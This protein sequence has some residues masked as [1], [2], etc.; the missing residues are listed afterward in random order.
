MLPFWPW[1]AADRNRAPLVLLLIALAASAAAVAGKPHE[2]GV[3]RMDVAVES[4]AIWV[5]LDTPLEN[6][7]GFE[8]APRTAAE[9]ERVE[10]ALATLRQP[11]RWLVPDAAAGCAAATVEIE[12]P[13]L[14]VPQAP[15]TAASNSHA[16]LLARV[17]FQCADATRAAH[18]DL[19]LFKAFPHLKRVEVQLVTPR[20]QSSKALRP[21]ASRLPLAR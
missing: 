2:H 13:V 19:E 21:A 8:R 14:G 15:P 4:R 17:S 10:Q 12:A 7:I 11:G 3:A 9:R 6:L 20:T 16:D 1:C 5:T 18:L